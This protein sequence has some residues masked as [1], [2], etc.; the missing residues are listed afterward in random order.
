MVRGDGRG[1]SYA[2]G[3]LIDEY[4][5]EIYFDLKEFWGLDLVAFIA[6]EVHST[7]ALILAMLRQ[8]PE[9][10]RFAAA[11]KADRPELLEP[12]AK[13]VDKRTKSIMD[14]RMWNTDRRL[15]ATL[16]N[17]V[18]MNT[19]VSGQWPPDKAPKLPTVGPLEWQPEEIAKKKVS[20]QPPLENNY[21]VLRKM[22]WTGG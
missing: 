1:G 12:P 21:D 18:Y 10:S 16:I 20:E 4:G 15:M 7:P 9:H 11:I 8:L 22:G 6:G 17:S 19:L 2:L 14:T 3:E 5:E 13:G